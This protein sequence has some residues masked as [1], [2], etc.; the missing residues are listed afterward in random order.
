MLWRSFC[1][2][3][4]LYWVVE[5]AYNLGRRFES[6]TEKEMISMVENLLVVAKQVGVLFLLISVGFGMG[7]MGK[8]DRHT[9]DRLS[10]LLLFVVNP[11]IVI[12]ALQVPFTRQ[13]LFSLGWGC[14]FLVFQFLLCI[15]MS[16]LTFR[17][18][19]PEVRCI[20]R[21]AQ[22][23]CNSAYMG[24]PLIAAV[25]GGD[26]L[27]YT[28]PTMIVFSAFQWT[29]GVALL[30]G[31]VSVKKVLLNPGIMGIGIGLFLFVTQLPLPGVVDTTLETLGSMNTPLA[32]LIIGG[33]MAQADLKSVV[34]KPPL[35][36]V[37][38]LRLV[39]LP[40]LTLV[41]M[42]PLRRVDTSLFCALTILAA[43]PT[44]TATSIMSQQYG[45][46]SVT[47]AQVV[48]LSTLLSMVTLPFFA[49]LAQSLV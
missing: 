30:G 34:R 22:I 23:Y 17:K 38:A 28:V 37:S 36:A 16:M 4:M 21:Y 24:I 31:K 35:Y 43:T 49:A 5:L 15:G 13:L 39:V 8:L 1:A 44:A 32:M 18:A 19:A 48:T 41:I 25:M 11:C 33:Q 45:G 46:D 7:R 40:A 27:F 10:T 26:G 9:L 3:L 29:Y 6:E 20:Y 42:L 47:A 12:N 2:I 14:L